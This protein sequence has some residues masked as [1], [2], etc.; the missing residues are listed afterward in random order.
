VVRYCGMEWT[1]FRDAVVR[2]PLV[3]AVVFL[4]LGIGW[5]RGGSGGPGSGKGVWA[6]RILL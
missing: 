6:G 1:K 2:R 3:V 5:P 4:I